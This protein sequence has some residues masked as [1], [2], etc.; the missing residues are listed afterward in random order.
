MRPGVPG[1]LSED[2]LRYAAEAGFGTRLSNVIVGSEYSLLLTQVRSVFFS[3]SFSSF[4]SSFLF[5]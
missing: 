5:P 3:L 1:F 2:T 4:S